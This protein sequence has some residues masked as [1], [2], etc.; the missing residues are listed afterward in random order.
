ML[1]SSGL[2]EDGTTLGAAMMDEAAAG[3]LIFVGALTGKGLAGLEHQDLGGQ[4]SKCTSHGNIS[5]AAQQ[6]VGD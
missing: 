1:G 6:W 2:D 3:T 4:M 5:L